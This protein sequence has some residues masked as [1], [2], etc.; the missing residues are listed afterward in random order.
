MGSVTPGYCIKQ[1][2]LKA[3][4]NIQVDQIVRNYPEPTMQ[5]IYF[6]VQAIYFVVRE[7]PVTH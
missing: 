7:L 5:A 3:G 4:V 1:Q 2:G 6:P